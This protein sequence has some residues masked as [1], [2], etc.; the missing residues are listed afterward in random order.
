M[1]EHAK[2]HYKKITKNLLKLNN[3][4]MFGF[5]DIGKVK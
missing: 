2:S 3:G 5:E 1:L 4:A